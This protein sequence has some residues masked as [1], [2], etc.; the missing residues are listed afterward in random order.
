MSTLFE[1]KTKNPAHTIQVAKDL[2]KKLKPGHVLGLVGQLGSG[3]TCF[4]KGLASGLGLKDPD[5]VTS[6]SFVLL[7]I[8]PGKTRLCHFDLYRIRWGGEII[9]FGFY[10]Y[11]DNSII[12]IEWAE[13]VPQEILGEYLKVE[14]EITGKNT[15]LIRF[16]SPFEK[17]ANLFT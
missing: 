6:P 2:A 3:K 17:Y 8:Y 10:D 15:R 11:L 1:I 14:F 4:V 16:T 12:A 9:E 13:K 7:N 5:I